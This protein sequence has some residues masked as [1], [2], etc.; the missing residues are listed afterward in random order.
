M[1]D[2]LAKSEAAAMARIEGDDGLGD[3]PAES[4]GQT[5]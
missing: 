4:G 3:E 1:V 5:A 2:H